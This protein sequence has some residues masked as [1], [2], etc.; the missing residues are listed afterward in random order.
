MNSEHNQVCEAPQSMRWRPEWWGKECREG[1]RDGMKP[2]RHRNG[3][4]WGE[5]VAYQNWEMNKLMC[6]PRW[7]FTCNTLEEPAV[8]SRSATQMQESSPQ[9][10]VCVYVCV[11]RKG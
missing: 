2:N 7:L 3:M 5:D 8:I 11:C 10:L 4:G 1:R 9:D 6:P